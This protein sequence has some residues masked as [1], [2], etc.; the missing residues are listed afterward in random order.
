[1]KL[2]VNAATGETVFGDP[3]LSYLVIA[4]WGVVA[5]LL[6]AWQLNRRQA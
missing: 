6:L 1:M 3:W 2:A 5:Y 4:A